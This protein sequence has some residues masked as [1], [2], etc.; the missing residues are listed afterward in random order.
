MH[1]SK[2]HHKPH[3]AQQPPQ[4][5][6]RR[7]SSSAADKDD[8]AAHSSSSSS[9]SSSSTA[10][11]AVLTLV[12]GDEAVIQSWYWDL[13]PVEKADVLSVSLSD[14]QSELRYS[15][16]AA[17][18]SACAARAAERLSDAAYM[19]TVRRAFVDA[20]HSEGRMDCTS[21]LQFLQSK[22]SGQPALDAV[23]S[24]VVG[25]MEAQLSLAHQRKQTV[26]ALTTLALFYVLFVS[27]L[28]AFIR[29]PVVVAVLGPSLYVATMQTAGPVSAPDP[30][31]AV[32]RWQLRLSSLVLLFESSTTVSLA[33]PALQ[34]RV[35]AFCSWLLVASWASYHSA[36]RYW[37]LVGVCALSVVMLELHMALLRAGGRE[38]LLW[39][40]SVGCR[41]LGQLQVLWL[42]WYSWSALT[43]CALFF[44]PAAATVALSSAC[45]TVATLLAPAL[46]LVQARVFDYSAHPVVLALLYALSLLWLWLYWTS[47]S[48]VVGVSALVVSLLLTPPF[49]TSGLSVACA[50]GAQ[51]LLAIGCVKLVLIAAQLAALL[52]C[53]CALMAGQWAWPRLLAWWERSG[54]SSRWKEV[55]WWRWRVVAWARAAA[56]NTAERF[57]TS[58]LAAWLASVWREA[59]ADN[60][61][62]ADASSQ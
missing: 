41:Y 13:H 60:A 1:R 52:A 18:A 49:L 33:S 22:P 31:P 2:A 54:W 24:T 30:Y 20:M 62:A 45:V 42:S 37:A 16:N 51:L 40:V 58:A 7:R 61:A 4:Q 44:F 43:F 34:M 59:G 53:S 55:G 26:V 56:G 14:V 10:D 35:E 19:G 48:F 8:D 15:L 32:R 28:S 36:A 9:T 57:S 47:S 38:R 5:R 3:R 50:A 11:A 25:L 27:S 46:Q 39:Y 12:N 21:V 6:D 17:D 23:T 29:Y